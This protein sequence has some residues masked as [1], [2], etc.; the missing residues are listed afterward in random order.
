MFGAD[1]ILNAS[2]R[3]A[4]VVTGNISGGS[5]TATPPTTST[6]NTTRVAANVASV[7]LLAALATRLGGT[8]FNGATSNLYVRLGAAAAIITPGAE[9][10]SVKIVPGAYYEIPFGWIGEIRGI[11]DAADASGYAAIEELT[12]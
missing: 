5:V 11:W 12:A 3:R 10:F 2:S 6:E 4:L 8:I 1:V 7:T 9:R